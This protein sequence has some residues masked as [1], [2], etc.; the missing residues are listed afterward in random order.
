MGPVRGL[1]RGRQ[2]L[3][4]ELL[5][6]IRDRELAIQL[7]MHVNA[8]AGVALAIGTRAEL[9]EAAVQL[10]RVVM[11]DSALILEAADALERCGNGPPGGLGM[12][13]GVGEAC[14]VAG[15]EAIEDALRVGKGGSLG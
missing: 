10:D 13:R 7:G 1:V 2:Y 15:E 11:L 6:S 5:A 14:V 3:G 8:H 4:S 12:R 9:D